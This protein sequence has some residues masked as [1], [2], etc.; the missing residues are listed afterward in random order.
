MTIDVGDTSK[1]DGESPAI[2]QANKGR[3]AEL[4]LQSRK[5]STNSQKHKR[6]SVRLFP[7]LFVV[8]RY[9]QRRTRNNQHARILNLG[10]KILT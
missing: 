10:T 9:A 7:E 3:S 1:T 2:A 8:R 5:L 4:K 6:Q